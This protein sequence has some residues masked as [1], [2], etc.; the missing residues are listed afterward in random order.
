M[1]ISVATEEDV[2]ALCTL[3]TLLFSQEVE[4]SPSPEKQI[5]GLLKIILNPHVGFVLV[6][7][8]DGAIVGM[9]NVLFTVS[10]AL[11][12]RVAI[13]EDMV[14]AETRRGD[15]LGSKLIEQA[16]TVARTQQCKRIT[17]LTDASNLAAQH[18]YKRHG[19]VQ[20]TMTPMRLTLD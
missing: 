1:Q 6:G 15:G 3:L 12:E 14:I 8:I 18:F 5:R 2:P 9:V 7:K 11:G 13:L 10:T 19:F 17:L 4:F 20:S 16:I